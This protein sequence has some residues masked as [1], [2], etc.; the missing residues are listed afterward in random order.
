MSDKNAIK[1]LQNLL[2][3][4]G[5]WFLDVQAPDIPEVEDICQ[6][7][8]ENTDARLPELSTSALYNRYLR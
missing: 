8:R 5:K 3:N 7:A 2:Q 6:K 1:Q 4:K